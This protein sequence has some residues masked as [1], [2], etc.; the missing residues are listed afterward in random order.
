MRSDP[1]QIVS[2]KDCL[3]GSFERRHAHGALFLDQK[4]LIDTVHVEVVLAG[5]Q[6]LDWVLAHKHFLAHDAD[7]LPERGRPAA[8]GLH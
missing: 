5:R 7:L 8:T 4:P 3:L 1:E 6:H 2:K